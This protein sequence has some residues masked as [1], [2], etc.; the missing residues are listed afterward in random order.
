MLFIF[1]DFENANIFKSF[2]KDIKDGE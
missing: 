1:E 2:D